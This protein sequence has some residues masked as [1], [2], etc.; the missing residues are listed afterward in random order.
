MLEVVCRCSTE[1]ILDFA[2]IGAKLGAD[3]VH[4]RCLAPRQS[5]SSRGARISIAWPMS[6]RRWAA[7]HTASID[8]V[9]AGVNQLHACR[10]V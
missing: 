7:A 4:V 5:Q 6:V 9:T 1:C 2:C 8:T 10:Q 3:L